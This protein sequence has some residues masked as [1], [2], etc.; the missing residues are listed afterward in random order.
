MRLSRARLLARRVAAAFVSAVLGGAAIAAGAR[1][2]HL[3]GLERQLADEVRA[4]RA[5]GL[6]ERE[7]IREPAELVAARD[8]LDAVLLRV[9]EV[10]HTEEGLAFGGPGTQRPEWRERLA[11]GLEARAELLT[12]LDAALAALRDAPREP[13]LSLR[14]QPPPHEFHGPSNS[15]L[16]LRAATNLLC[17]QAWQ[18]AREPCGG[19]EAGHWLGRA[20]RLVRVTDDGGGFELAIRVALEAI[21]TDTLERI[22]DEEIVDRD[23]LDAAVLDELAYDVS[24]DRLRLSVECDLAEVARRVE[25][26]RGAYDESLDDVRDLQQTLDYLRFGREALDADL[27]QHHAPP[28]RREVLAMQPAHEHSLDFF[29]LSRDQAGAL[30]ARMRCDE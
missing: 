17:G 13:S 30:R 18:A 1:A 21:V 25:A 20:L 23:A 28:F 11:A 14:S 26:G 9:T 2:L 15:L 5:T 8:R 6:I 29:A 12:E 24:G 10:H 22:R 19:H 16:A 7:Q 4:V 3:Q 27:T